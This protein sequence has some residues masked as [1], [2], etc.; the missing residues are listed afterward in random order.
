[1]SSDKEVD[2]YAKKMEDRFGKIPEELENLL[3][4]VKIRNTGASLGFDKVIIKNGL[5]I[6]FFVSNPMSPYYKSKT[7][8]RV[9]SRITDCGE[10]K[11]ELKQTENKLKIVV[12]NIPT[13]SS[14]YNILCR[15]R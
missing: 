11:I 5:M 14:A 15:L 7:F 12:R 8:E 4:V 9:L 1:M 6:A 10:R 3:F 2:D 13:L